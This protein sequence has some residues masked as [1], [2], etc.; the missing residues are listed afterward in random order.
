MNTVFFVCLL[1]GMSWLI[2]LMIRRVIIRRIESIII[3]QSE[4]QHHETKREPRPIRLIVPSD[5][6]EDDRKQ[7]LY[8]LEMLEK[9][10]AFEKHSD[11]LDLMV[12]LRGDVQV[13]GQSR[14]NGQE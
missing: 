10:G 6:S 7:L 2:F 1:A 4:V 5:L 12:I 9:T 3:S 11:F 14:R 13:V 8:R